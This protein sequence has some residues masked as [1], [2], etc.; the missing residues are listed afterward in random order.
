MFRRSRDGATHRARFTGE[1]LIRRLALLLGLSLTLPFVAAAASPELVVRVNNVRDG[2]GL[3]HVDVCPEALFL[4]EDCPY[5]ADAP[6]RPGT[7]EVVIR[8][9]PPGHYAVQTFHDENANHR[10]DR[11]MFGIP[12]EG[13]G[14]SNDAPIHLGPPKWADAQFE[15][16]GGAQVISITTHYFT[17]ASGPGKV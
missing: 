4:K 13:I 7:T 6:A 10:V 16:H 8:G 11:G 17:G 15:F 12:R 14:F 5:S 3:V 2:R 9:L 1:L